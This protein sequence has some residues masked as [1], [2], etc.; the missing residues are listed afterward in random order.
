[1]E[2]D[3]EKTLMGFYTTRWVEA[4]DH[5]EAKSLVL[6]TLRSEPAL[7]DVP[8]GCGAEIF[9]EEVEPVE[10]GDVPEIQC[11]FTFFPSED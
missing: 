5:E 8:Q 2:V 11:G 4:A 3:G 6:G 1:M 9:W 7:I 10:A